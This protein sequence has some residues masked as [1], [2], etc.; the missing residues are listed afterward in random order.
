[1]YL[2]FYF[3]ILTYFLLY[4]IVKIYSLKKPLIFATL[5]CVLFTLAC[6]DP[7]DLRYETQKKIVYVE[8]DL[9]DY[10]SNQKI[11]VWQN[12]PT[13]GDPTFEPILDAKVVVN[14]NN[15]TQYNAVH[16]KEGI[17]NLPADFKVK[18]NQPYTLT[19][20]MANGV[21]YESSVETVPMKAPK[22]DSMYT[23]FKT[24]GITYDSKLLSGHDV[25][26]D[27]TDSPI[28]GQ[29]YMW[30]WV[31]YEKRD[32]CVSCL[33]GRFYVNPLPNGQCIED[34]FLKQRNVTYDYECRSD[35]WKVI[36]SNRFNLMSDRLNNGKKIGARL[37]GSI[38]LLQYKA[39]LV[40]AEQF[41]ISKKAFDYYSLLVSQ[42]QSTG[43]LTDTPP[44]AL[45]GNMKNPQNPT[46]IVGGV[47]S[48][49]SK[50]VKAFWLK[51]LERT[52]NVFPYGLNENGRANQPE[53]SGTD[54]TRP[55]ASPCIE[56]KNN[57]GKKPFGWQ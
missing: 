48:I 34:R 40:H 15:A 18:I 57:T 20:V 33:G 7:Y 47:F 12:L 53:P 14:E 49:A 17:Y 41:M 52:P 38:P 56:G 28:E 9:N 27:L 30:K 50:T 29:Y 8:A 45:N 37:L 4:C 22:V 6:V 13:T 32:Y 55:P 25:Y 46:E 19:I 35:C 44:V 10:D 26:L 31:L 36:Y 5:A 1:M 16:D 54:T 51:R 3:I 21:R 23:E 42:G 24:G 43:T 39:A 11:R 2:D